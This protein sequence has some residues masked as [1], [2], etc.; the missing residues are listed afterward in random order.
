MGSL[1]RSAEGDSRRF[2]AAEK[3]VAESDKKA[4]VPLLESARKGFP[5][6]K[7][8]VVDGTNENVNTTTT[9]QKINGVCLKIRDLAE[10]LVRFRN[11][12]DRGAIIRR[13]V[14]LTGLFSY[15]LLCWVT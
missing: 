15:I 11:G 2:E 14:W 12:N 6:Q 13:G 9:I 4:M 3:A 5:R 7:A 8:L 10:G 1:L